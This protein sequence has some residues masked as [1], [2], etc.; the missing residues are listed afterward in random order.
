MTPKLLLIGWD[1]ADWQIASTLMDA[2]Q[3]PF[4]R[5]LVER[6]ASGDLETIDP[7]LSPMLWTTIATGKRAYDHGVC[8]FTDVSPE[9]KVRPVGAASRKCRAV[10][11]ILAQHG[12]RC[13][14]ISWFA[15]HG[16]QI[17]GG[18]V[19]SN[20]YQ[21][22]TAP[23]GRPWPPAPRGTIWPEDHLET[24]NKL[25][26]SPLEIDEPLV[27]LF[28]PEAEK[29]D[30]DK[31]RRL[32]HLRVHLAEAFSVQA[33]AT[34]TMEHRP[35]DFMA[36]YFRAIDEICHHFMPFHPPRLDGVPEDLF[37]LYK[38]VVNSAYRL[39]DLMLGRLLAL[40]GPD[41]HVILCSDHGFYSDHLRPKFVPKVPAGITVW[42]RRH[43][44]FVAA[45]P[46]FAADE[47][48]FGANLL[49][50]A[51]TVLELYGLPIGEDMEGKPL[52]TVF[53]EPR[54]PRFIPTWETTERSAPSSLL[55]D[56]E[57]RALLET[58][59][60][61]GY[62]DAQQEPPDQRVR[63]TLRENNWSLAR[64][65][66]DGGKPERAL[67]IL[68]DLI[69]E[70]PERQDFA[71]RL[72]RCQAALGLAEEARATLA[73]VS[74]T[75]ADAPSRRLFEARVAVDERRFKEAAPILDEL[76]ETRSG[77]ADFWLLVAQTNVQLRRWAQGE[78]AA[79]QCLDL[80]PDEPAAWLSLGICL[81]RQGQAA[82]ASDAALA[83]VNLAF[84]N[85]LGHYVLGICQLVLGEVERAEAALKTALR[86][87]PGFAR[88]HHWMA[89][90]YRQT[91]RP[92][93]AA[94][95]T[96]LR[97]LAWRQR[98]EQA[99]NVERL[100]AE[101]AE[102]LRRRPPRPTPISAVAMH[103][104]LAAVAGDSP[105]RC[106][107]SKTFII[108]SGLPRSGTSLTMQMLERGGLPPMT[109]GI[110]R[111]DANNEQGYYEW[112]EIRKLPANPHIIEQAEGKAVKIVTPLL[113]AL[114]KQHRYKIL[115][116]RRPLAE[117][118]RS[119][120][121]MRFHCEGDPRELE[122]A[123]VPMLQ[124]HLDATLDLLHRTPQI[125]LLEIDFPSLVRDPAPWAERIAAFVG[126]E[127]L[128]EAG[129]M[130]G[131][132][133]SDLHRQRVPATSGAD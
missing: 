36:V 27:R 37:H 7:V 34:W 79:R 61:L 95:H 87:A 56:D 90:L 129:A 57:S 18:S 74:E 55:T 60:A 6:G 46:H 91:N 43:G 109:D 33:A 3:M 35:W 131:V 72:A 115:F 127:R 41:V 54:E 105:P 86:Y 52:A 130:S 20:L 83:S 9:G 75:L 68:E 113:P 78:A 133:R 31:D 42:H 8:G 80:K 38:E 124:K 45:G 101:A 82:E 107:N 76:R 13:H 1:S 29:V 103:S 92:G 121:K 84:A 49:D 28:V 5:Q 23:P 77:D 85:P 58:F 51:P 100:R 126:P 40:A 96:T 65:M 117:V 125:E 26:V 30:Q 25:R 2:G 67:P 116:M 16:E 15:T 120:H 88:A 97:D 63:S 111:P 70:N 106:A 69:H 10:W 17:P 14:V 50:V 4:L 110:R 108:V 132:V 66:L 22:P 112:E 71:Q 122:A 62:I 12:V 21:A 81:M 73:A 24:L 99:A 44:V 59:A 53:R 128:P 94:I 32:G 118:A 93:P 39:H 114:P 123:V 102:R 11:E 98:R 19:V 89:R 104:P 48:V 119:Q 47:L 64:A